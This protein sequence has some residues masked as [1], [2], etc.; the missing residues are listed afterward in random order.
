MEASG[1]GGM[2][3]G[4]V[5]SVVGAAGLNIPLRAVERLT[6]AVE[7]ASRTLERL[8][9]ATVHLDRVDADFL[10]RV[11]ETL[12]LLADMSEDTGAIRE[13]L[14]ALEDEVHELRTTV[15]QRL[16]RVPLLRPRK[17]QDRA[18]PSRPSPRP[19]LARRRAR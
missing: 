14:D 13:R 9:R 4:S 7:N 18:G 17:Q 1:F 6:T 3:R 16:D 12:D 8:E 15:T 5:N 10:D 2:L 11:S 19:K